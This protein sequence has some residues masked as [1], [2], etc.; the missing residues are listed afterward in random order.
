MGP[1]IGGSIVAIQYGLNPALITQ[2]V[3]VEIL[4]SFL[5]LPAW[6]WGLALI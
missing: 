3:G 1:M 6:W 5:T 2:M 4:L